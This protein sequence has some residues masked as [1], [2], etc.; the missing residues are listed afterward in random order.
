M[1]IFSTYL[2][3]CRDNRKMNGKQLKS[4]QN[5]SKLVKK[6]FILSTAILE[7]FV[8]E[9]ELFMIP[10]YEFKMVEEYL[11]QYIFSIRFHISKRCSRLAGKPEGELT[12]VVMPRLVTDILREK[13]FSSIS[14]LFFHRLRYRFKKTFLILQMVLGFRNFFIFCGITI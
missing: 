10:E 9:G 2:E 5:S 12:L 11:D 1:N 7:E 8:F 3:T 13:L 6:L 14:L 4:H